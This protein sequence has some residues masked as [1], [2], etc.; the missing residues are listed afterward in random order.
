[1]EEFKVVGLENKCMAKC[2]KRKA[3]TLYIDGQDFDFCDEHTEKYREPIRK[4]E[5]DRL[6][7]AYPIIAEP[8]Q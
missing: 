4:F 7:T 8:V 2:Y 1:M 5:E 6:R 3:Q